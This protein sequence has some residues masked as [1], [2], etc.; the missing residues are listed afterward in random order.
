MEQ[1]LIR[2]DPAGHS[3]PAPTVSN[4]D[5]RAFINAN[6]IPSTLEEIRDDHLIPVFVKDNE[7]VISHHD[8]INS[9]IQVVNDIYNGEHILDPV[10]RLSHP[11]KGR[12]PEAKDKPANQ[13][14][15]WEKTVFYE[16]MMFAIEIPSI[17][18]TIDG[19][20]L[21]LTV[22]GVKAYNL[23]NLY[24]KKGGAEH[25]KIFVGFKNTVCTNL[26]IW[27]DGYIK[28]L[29]VN[30][31]GMLKSSIQSLVQSYSSNYQLHQLKQLVNHHLT[32]QQFALLIGRCRMYP[33]LPFGIKSDISQLEF[34][35]TQMS[36]VCRDF[37]TDNSFCKDSQGNINLWKLYNLFTGANKT[38]Y[39][40]TFLDRSVN[41][42]HFVDQ[43]K[44]GLEKK[45]SN[46]YL[47]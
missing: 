35:D 31:I 36:T 21:S 29:R 26:C 6:T 44:N 46:W 32:E 20:V 27:S 13:L 7:T 40:D 30:S 14:L 43:I 2:I 18:E 23:D 16:R 3:Q 15:E 19:N 11:I 1:T 34:T 12:I 5:N 38:S 45:V 37:Y 8:F 41:A 28:D 17:Y 39:I 9:T 4:P 22:G 33:H 47:N 24:N 10:V 42:Y 25:F